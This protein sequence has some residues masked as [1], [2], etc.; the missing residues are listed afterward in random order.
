MLV[1]R[2]FQS[3]GGRLKNS[4]LESEDSLHLSPAFA[5]VPSEKSVLEMQD[6]KQ[7]L[8][9]ENRCGW[10][11]YGAYKPLIGQG[12]GI[13]QGGVRNLLREISLHLYAETVVIA[14]RDGTIRIDQCFSLGR[15]DEDGFAPKSDK[16]QDGDID[17]LSYHRTKFIADRT[18]F[19]NPMQVRK[20]GVESIRIGLRLENINVVEL[21]PPS[22][23][24]ASARQPLLRPIV[25]SKGWRRRESNKPPEI[26]NGLD[27]K[28]LGI[29]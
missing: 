13:R 20:S 11:K 24:R 29:P 26:K 4:L 25:R 5:E 12:A 1:L 27:Y 22:L 23:K 16:Q 14:I 10:A 9:L 6:S 21:H 8:D 19:V 7:E 3:T 2:G 18:E 28:P 15:R 17:E